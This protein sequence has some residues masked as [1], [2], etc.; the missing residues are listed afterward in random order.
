MAKKVVNQEQTS[1]KA[2]NARLV[3][4]RSRYMVLRELVE[5][6]NGGGNG[7]PSP[8]IRMLELTDN[9]TYKVTSAKP[10]VT[11]DVKG[12]IVIGDR[13]FYRVPASPGAKGM[14]A[15]ILSVFDVF[16]AQRIWAN[17]IKNTKDRETWR[18]SADARRQI[19]AVELLTGQKVTPEQ[20][21][22][23]YQKYLRERGLERH[24]RP[25]KPK[26]RKNSKVDGFPSFSLKK[27]S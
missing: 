12:T 19:E 5:L 13:T 2:K 25:Q 9:G 26:T 22:I 16:D 27:K 11:E 17:K 14:F 4:K 21:N 23:L 18:E 10:E 6:V 3:I 7:E 1:T 20:E 8:F 24:Q 15:A